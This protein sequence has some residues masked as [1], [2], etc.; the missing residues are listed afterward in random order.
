[1]LFIKHSMMRVCLCLVAL[2]VCSTIAEPE[3]D[4]DVFVLTTSNF[5]DFVAGDISLVEFYAPW[6]GHCKTLAPEYA[7][8]ATTLVKDNVRL[9][10]VDATVESELG[11]RFGVTGYPTLK[12]FRQGTASD[13]KGPRDAAGIAS[14][15]QKQAV[16]AI[17]VFKNLAE[18]EKFVQDDAAV[19]YFGE[20]SGKAHKTFEQVAAQQ[21]ETFRFGQTTAEDILAKYGHKD[22]VVLVQST[23]YSQS[24]LEVATLA[25]KEGDLLAF[26]N[27]NILP[28][29]GE[30][31]DDN[32]A[33]YHNKDVPLVKIYSDLNWQLNSKGANYLLNK[34]RKVA[35]EYKDKFVFAVASKGK[36]QKEVDD[37]GLPKGE[38]PFVIH[39]TKKG[40]KYPA[41]SLFSGESLKEHLD[42]FLGNKLESYVKS[43]PVPESQPEDGPVVVVGKNFE[44]VV[45][46]STK[47]VLLE[48]YAPWC[49]H[50]K[51]LEPKYNE[52]AQKMKK[53]SNSLT[54]AK[55]D[56]TANDLPPKFAVSGF[57][58]IFFVPANKKD[59]PVKYDGARE[60]S[61]FVSYIK[62]HASIPLKENT[63]HQKEEL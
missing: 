56:A 6:C 4:G 40:H 48:A 53:Y 22:E 23:R 45:L 43:E 26:I 5:D 7:K 38:N 37:F 55:V 63:T 52:L 33:H 62:K 50:C 32:Q 8:A 21:R 34:V 58:T 12:V 60:V 9:A 11:S 18:L 14:Y 24:P 44:E 10:K 54:I 20:A 17:S 39:D 51:T 16:P 36:Y 19:V 31:T 3:K 30:I 13:Y 27:K 47:D 46:D 29:V 25:H 2:L 49:G 59:A 1:M 41:S 28:L 15:M 42:A 61:D 35:K 57:P